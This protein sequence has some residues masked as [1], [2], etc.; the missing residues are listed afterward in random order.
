MKKFLIFLSFTSFLFATA[1]SEQSSI[2]NTTEATTEITVEQVTSDE[3]R[4]ENEDMLNVIYEA[5]LSENILKNHKNAILHSEFQKID[6][7][8]DYYSNKYIEADKYIYEGY[9]YD[10]DGNLIYKPELMVMENG[11]AYSYDEQND[12]AI[13]YIFMDG[14][15]EREF[16]LCNTAP[17]FELADGE[18]VSNVYEDDGDIIVETS[19]NE[20]AVRNTYPESELLDNL[21]EDDEVTFQYK[22]NAENYE[23]LEFNSYWNPADAEPVLLQKANLQYDI[24]PFQLSAVQYPITET[25]QDGFDESDKNNGFFVARQLEKLNNPE[26]H[27]VTITA[28]PNTENE[29]VYSKTIGNGVQAAV[30]L[31]DNYEYLYT[32]P[33][34]TQLFTGSEKINTEKDSVY[35][36]K[37]SE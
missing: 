32:D 10:D 29:K 33:E 5:N 17:F 6:G 30:Y 16:E 25:E 15:Y 35:Y 22:L 11:D 9:N 12:L 20:N 18:I 13:S 4:I 28:D 14:C 26:T 36:T 2:D 21:S 37:K 19:L 23:L 7:N 31:A 27:T 1:C 3:S 8:N 34:C 24:E